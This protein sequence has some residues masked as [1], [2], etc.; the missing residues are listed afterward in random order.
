[1]P[2]QQARG[3]ISSYLVTMELSNGSVLNINES[4]DVSVET[5]AQCGMDLIR[6]EPSNLVSHAQQSYLQC[7]QEHEQSCFHYCHLSVPAKEVKDIGV[8]A[9]TKVGKSSPALVA[10]PR[11]G[12]SLR[13]EKMWV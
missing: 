10:L 5:C 13:V 1:M 8:T 7:P 11:T 4:V 6:K 9:N 3:S 12:K 2:R